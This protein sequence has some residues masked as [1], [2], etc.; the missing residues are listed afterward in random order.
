VIDTSRAELVSDTRRGRGR[1]QQQ[2]FSTIQIAILTGLI[3]RFASFSLIF[4]EVIRSCYCNYPFCRCCQG[5]LCLQLG[6]LL[7]VC[8]YVRTHSSCG[9]YCFSIGSSILLLWPMQ[10]R[11]RDS[12]KRGNVYTCPFLVKRE[13]IQ[14]KRSCSLNKY[15]SS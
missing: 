9:G 3:M 15:L 4:T 5:R 1:Q 11:R 14:N 10:E 8:L 7:S 2:L 6:Y 13:K 12:V